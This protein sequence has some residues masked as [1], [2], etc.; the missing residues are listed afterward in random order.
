MSQKIIEYIYNNPFGEITE[1]ILIEGKNY[2]IK[3]QWKR[4][5]TITLKPAGHIIKTTETSEIKK[6]RLISLI[7]RYT[8]YSLRG[9]RT[10]ILEKL[11]SNKY[12]PALLQYPA[13]KIL[14]ENNRIHYTATIRKKDI[15]QLEKIRSYF[16][17]LVITSK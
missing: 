8:Q 17:A 14:C 4:K 11:L 12:T 6:S 7:T 10:S 5:I 1:T 16:E 13:S 9:K 2:E 3:L 15:A